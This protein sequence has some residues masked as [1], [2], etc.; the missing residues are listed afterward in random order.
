MLTFGF[1]ATVIDTGLVKIR[2]EEAN[3][4][5]VDDVCLKI[6]SFNLAGK[7]WVLGTGCNCLLLIATCCFRIISNILSNKSSGGIT[8]GSNS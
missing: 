6:L 7:V 3:K 1:G 8:Y 2:F 4:P 5:P